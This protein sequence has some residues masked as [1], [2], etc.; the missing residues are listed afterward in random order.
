MHG[1]NDLAFHSSPQSFVVGLDIVPYRFCLQNL[2]L[3]TS[4]QTLETLELCRQEESPQNAEVT[5]IKVHLAQ[6]TTERWQCQQSDL[7][8]TSYCKCA[9]HAQLHALTLTLYRTQQ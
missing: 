7:T 6:T 5:T 2:A 8:M 9:R 1:E 3:Q 4:E